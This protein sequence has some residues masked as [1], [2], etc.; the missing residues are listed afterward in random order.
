MVKSPWERI[1][2]IA[3][4]VGLMLG[5]LSTLLI[6]LEINNTSIQLAGLVTLIFFVGLFSALMTMLIQDFI[7]LYLRHRA[8]TRLNT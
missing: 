1:Q 5:A 8:P 6:G 7:M 4:T 3:N 2:D